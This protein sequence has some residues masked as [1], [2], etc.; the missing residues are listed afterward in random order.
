M[1]RLRDDFSIGQMDKKARGRYVELGI[2]SCVLSFGVGLITR[3]GWKEGRGREI[4]RWNRS[5][6]LPPFCV[7]LGIYVLYLYPKQPF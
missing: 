5:I 6:P 4:L 1:E 7:Y 2:R 3:D